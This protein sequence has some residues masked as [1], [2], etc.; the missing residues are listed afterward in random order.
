MA[1]DELQILRMQIDICTSDVFPAEG[2]MREI[3]RIVAPIRFHEGKLH[4]YHKPVYGLLIFI[5]QTGKEH[6]CFHIHGT[7]GAKE[8]CRGVEVFLSIAKR[9]T[10]QRKIFIAN[11]IDISRKAHRSTIVERNIAAQRSRQDLDYPSFRKH[12]PALYFCHHYRLAQP[13]F[14]PVFTIH[15][16]AA[17]YGGL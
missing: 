8:L 15:E 10:A 5:F 3:R 6:V 17:F 2:I 16:E 11:I 14:R 12:I 4:A 9:L 7:I 13:R 1:E